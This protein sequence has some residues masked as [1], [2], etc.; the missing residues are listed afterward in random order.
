MTV[1]T[2]I[3][4]RLRRQR[5]IFG[6][7]AILLSVMALIFWILFEAS[8]EVEVIGQGFFSITR[9]SRNNTYGLLAVFFLLASVIALVSWLSSLSCVCVSTQCREDCILIHRG[10]IGCELYINEQKADSLEP[11]D[12]RYYL[13]GTLSDG[14]TVTASLSRHRAVHLS[15]SNGHPSVEL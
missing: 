9:V 2:Q 5:I 15:F 3:K 1:E 11:F 8:A 13:E 14:S 12:F 10:Y 4:R 7:A 6:S